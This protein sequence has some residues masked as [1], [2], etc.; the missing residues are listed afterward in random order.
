MSDPT[1]S[2]DGCDAPIRCVKRCSAHYAQWRRQTVA[3]YA[4]PCVID[5]C[6]KRRICK[7]MCKCHYER[8]RVHGDPHKLLRRQDQ[9]AEEVLAAGAKV[10]SK[11]GLLRLLDDFGRAAT[12]K[13]GRQRY[14]R[15]CQRTVGQRY[16]VEKPELRDPDHLQE[17][18]AKRYG[19]A[20]GQRASAAELRK[21]QQGRC[22]ICGTPE[23][24]VPGG[25]LHLDHE[26]AT[27]LVRG[28]LCTNCNT[29][30]GQFKDDP[31]RLLAA[32]DYL[33]RTASVDLT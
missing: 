25:L 6:D 23:A 1:C 26:H 9:R 14:C 8:W 24:D 12:R 31:S 13:D 16:Y 3:R 11:C 15:D 4:K 20:S 28:L 2:V 33:Q 10:C 17:L 32:V 21:S 19:R 27:S 29:G 5:G 18:A 22:A 30:L 7:G